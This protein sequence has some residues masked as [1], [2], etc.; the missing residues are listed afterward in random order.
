M[1]NLKLPTRLPWPQSSRLN[2]AILVRW[3]VSYLRLLA[4]LPH[5]LSPRL[6][7]EMTLSQAVNNT[8][9]ALGVLP[10]QG[11]TVMSGMSYL[12]VLT[13]LLRHQSSK[14]N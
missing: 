4:T 11:N 5:P 1:F 7:R 8:P 13:M 3:E 2:R 9:L 12:K 10:Q 14:L 6:N